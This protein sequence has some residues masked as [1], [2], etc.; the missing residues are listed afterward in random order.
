MFD[1]AQ[2][3]PPFEPIRDTLYR[4]KELMAEFADG[5]PQSIVQ[6]LDFRTF[7]YFL[8]NGRAAPNNPHAGRMQVLHDSSIQ[9]AMWA[10]LDAASHPS[11]E[12]GLQRPFAAMATRSRS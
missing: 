5:D 11:C 12:P 2:D 10:H 3:H 7:R 6:S 9:R 8:V 1:A 4:P